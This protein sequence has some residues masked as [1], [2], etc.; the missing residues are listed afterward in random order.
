MVLGVNAQGLLRYGPRILV[1][2]FPLL[3]V[4]MMVLNSRGV[5]TFSGLDEALMF[6]SYIAVAAVLF[7]AVPVV[8]Q[9]KYLMH[10]TRVGNKLETLHHSSSD[11]PAYEW[12]I[13]P[14]KYRRK[15]LLIAA[16]FSLETSM[17]EEVLKLSNEE[18]SIMA[19]LKNLKTVDLNFLAL[20]S[21]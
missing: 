21:A 19:A 4:V 12:S 2:A 1:L 10:L 7:I 11:F 14:V 6:V 13:F 16:G 17:T 15:A 3:C 5:V 8:L 20:Q 18:L 9:A